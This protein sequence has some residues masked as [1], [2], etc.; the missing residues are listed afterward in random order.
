MDLKYFLW[1]FIN[2]QRYW[3]SSFNILNF[4]SFHSWTTASWIFL[5]FG[6]TQI[7][8]YHKVNGTDRSINYS[9]WILVFFFGT[10]WYTSSKV[11]VFL[12]YFYKRTFR[13]QLICSQIFSLPNRHECLNLNFIFHHYVCIYYAKYSHT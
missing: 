3:L 1:M 13:L 12:F 2:N 11:L 8:L 5:L 6:H 10:S 9:N 7:L 4:N